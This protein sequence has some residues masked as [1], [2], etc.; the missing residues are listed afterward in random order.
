MWGL[1]VRA[2]V[3]VACACLV[4]VACGDDGDS[5]SDD[6]VSGRRPG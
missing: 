3:G 1:P 6:E 5:T 2:A 4:L